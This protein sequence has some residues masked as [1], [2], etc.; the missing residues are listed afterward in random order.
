MLVLGC[1]VAGPLLEIET[2]ALTPTVAVADAVLSEGCGSTADDETPAVFV[3]EPVAP[4]ETANVELIETICPAVSVPT[5]Q[6]N[7]PLQAPLLET[8]V[9]PAGGVS[10][11][12]TPTASDGPLFF[13]LI[14][15]VAFWPAPSVPVSVFAIVRSALG[16]MVV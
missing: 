15:Y 4:D 13:T 16:V 8:N 11:T 14:V 9:M 1:A 3:S 6:G 7:V 10:E 5:L 12:M 2:S